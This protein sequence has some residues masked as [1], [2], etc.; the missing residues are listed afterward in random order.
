MEIND[1]LVTMIT[2]ELLKRLQRGESLTNGTEKNEKPPLVLIGGSS[3]LSPAALTALESRFAVIP[4]DRAEAEFPEDAA[5]LVTRMSIQALTR[6]SEGDGGC[7]PE[8]YG[9]LRAILRGKTAV[10]L[11]E[12]MAWR[13][14]SATMPKAL[15]EKYCGHERALAAYGVKIV[16]DADIAAVFSGGACPSC[17]S[18]PVSAAPSVPAGPENKPAGKR[19]IS[20]REL[21][22]ACP[23]S[24]GYGQIFAIG[25]RDILT[26]LAADYVTRMRIVV[27]RPS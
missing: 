26:P 6:V 11:E 20:E 1:S 24:G 8:G 12:G 5:V 13:A 10:I 27:S 25:P 22:L 7:T 3:A 9:L 2:Q 14:F 16:K 19:V 4:H 21:M 15:L 23:E 17:P 18:R